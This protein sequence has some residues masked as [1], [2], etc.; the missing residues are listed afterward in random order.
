MQGDDHYWENRDGKFTDRTKEFF[1][2]SPWGAMG[3]KFFDYNLDGELDLILTDM[4]SDM[5]M[6]QDPSVEKQKSEIFFD[7]EF[8]ASDG[9]N[10]WGNAF[11]ENRGGGK[12]EEVSDRIGAENYWPWGVSV[13]DLNADGYEDVFIAS[14][15]NYPFRYGV[16][17]VLLNNNGEKLMESAFLLGVEPRRGGAMDKVWFTLDCSG[18]DRDHRH[19]QGGEGEPARD[20]EVIV[21]G[22][23]GTRSSVLV[24]FDDD[25][26]LDIITSEFNAEPQVLVSDLADRKEI[27]FLKVRLV[28]TKS[29]RSGVG[30]TVR[31]HAGSKTYTKLNDGKSG[32]L[33]QSDFPL[34]F[35]LGDSEKV[36]RVE[37]TWPGG[38]TQAVTDAIPVND[39]LVI[40]EK[41]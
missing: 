32:Y 6:P 12:F 21:R 7:P 16:N 29:N 18:P 13:D 31:V 39:L 2:M 11:W 40:E 14:S 8:L 9:D 23:L 17:S 34:Y 3:V 35:G 24:D 20:G 25:G 1:P 37:V 33:S 22:A 10:I 36:D 41:G 4:H 15:M 30:A 28:G 26:D 27:R 5:S 38:A 19:C